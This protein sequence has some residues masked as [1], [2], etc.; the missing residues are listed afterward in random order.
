MLH[1]YCSF[2]LLVDDIGSNNTTRCQLLDTNESSQLCAE[3]TIIPVK[4]PLALT[5]Y[6]K[7]PPSTN[8]VSI[9]HKQQYLFS[10]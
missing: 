6:I 1:Q 3:G 7:P 4:V 5:I 9:T 10:L 8:T 2:M